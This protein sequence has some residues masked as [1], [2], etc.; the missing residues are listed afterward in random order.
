ML[1][2]LLFLGPDLGAVLAPLV[3][4]IWIEAA[5]GIASSAPRT[6]NRVAAEEDRDEDDEGLDLGRSLLDLRLDQ[7]VLDLLVDDREDRPR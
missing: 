1:A 2:S 6:P 5:V 7:V 3:D 4:A